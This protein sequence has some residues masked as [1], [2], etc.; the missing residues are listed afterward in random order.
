MKLLGI[1]KI[2]LTRLKYVVNVCKLSSSGNH[3]LIKII[4]GFINTNTI[5]VIVIEPATFHMCEMQMHWKISEAFLQTNAPTTEF[6]L[7][8]QLQ[9]V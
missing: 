3:S 7:V 5:Y 8:L 2:V 4:L 9:A 1:L 6:A